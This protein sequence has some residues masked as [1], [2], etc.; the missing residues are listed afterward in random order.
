LT[1]FGDIVLFL[2][3]TGGYLLVLMRRLNL[4]PKL[5]SNMSYYPVILL[6]LHATELH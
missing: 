5:L 3:G 2:G 6:L 4:P 1:K